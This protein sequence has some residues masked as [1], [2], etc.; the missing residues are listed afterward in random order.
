VAHEPIAEAAF[1]LR[2]FERDEGSQVL[3]EIWALTKGATSL[4]KAIQVKAD[5]WHPTHV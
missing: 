5:S 4:R 3:A 2:P 1:K